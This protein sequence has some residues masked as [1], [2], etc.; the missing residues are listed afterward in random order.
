[1]IESQESERKRIAAELHDGLGQNL[2]IIKNKLLV[3]L[4]SLNKKESTTLQVEEAS[5]VV[6]STIE[7]VRSIS[8]NLR[9]HQ[10]DQLGITKTLR[11]IV[12]QVNEATAI[13]FSAEIQD[14]DGIL[15]PEQEI[16][17]FR[18]VQE[19]FNNIIKHSGATKVTVT[20]ERNK[21][22][23]HLAIADNGK[24]ISSS[25]GFGIS[26]MQERAK[27]F[28]WELLITSKE[29]TELTLRIS[30]TKNGPI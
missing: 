6:S 5:D 14:I 4:Q 19:S 27:M 30:N 1:L 11:S 18:I 15:S 20:V 3:A 16:S 21:N 29:G 8:H 7:E 17:L 10:L 24:G 12:R 13:E 9:P 23:I 22:A 26:G 28:G 2:L 25:Q